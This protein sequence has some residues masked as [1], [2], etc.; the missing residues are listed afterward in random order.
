MLTNQQK[1]RVALFGG[2]FVFQGVVLANLARVG[3]DTANTADT[4]VSIVKKHAADLDADDLQALK[5]L[6]L[7]D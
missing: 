2:A 1:F 6:N 3:F 5:H 7:M 4:L